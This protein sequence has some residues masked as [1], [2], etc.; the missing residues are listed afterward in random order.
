MTSHQHR[1]HLALCF[2]IIGCLLLFQN[3]SC[4]KRQ[5]LVSKKATISDIH[6]AQSIVFP[7]EG[8]RQVLLLESYDKW[9]LELQDKDNK[10]LD[11]ETQTGDAGT[12]NIVV[13]T[14]ENKGKE[15][16]TKVDMLLAN[17]T[18]VAT[19]R[20]IQQ[21]AKGKG[22]LGQEHIQGNID[23]IELPRFSGSA[24]DYF[25]TH[26]VDGGRRV[27]YSIEYHTPLRHARWVCFSFDNVTAAINTERN[28]AW[29]WD[30]L[31]P[32]SYEVTREHFKGFDR[33]HLV[34]S[35]DRVFSA[36]ANKQTFFYTNMSP[37][38]AKF[39][40]VAWQQLERTVQDWAHTEGFADNIY[41]AKGGTIRP[42][43]Y[44]D[45]LSGGKIA[46]PKHYWM[47]ILV[48]KDGEWRSMAFWIG[49]D[50][51]KRQQG[52]LASL[53]CSIDE[54]EKRTGLDFFFNLPDDI[55]NVVEAQ[56]PANSTEHWPGL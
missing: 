13:N 31:V 52:G 17:G 49:H 32:P 19:L 46:V 22:L 47:A 35:F 56:I 10:W 50:K 20:F 9:T 51:D 42:G 43:E 44:E 38:R 16:E 14:S 48:Q 40:Q 26:H 41:I 30:P 27:N 24:D 21:G 53:T 15:R 55:E 23:L 28:D 54:L 39:N 34:A 7:K 25:I 29:G 36:E 2:F 18:K 6:G 12:S 11:I 45:E 33:G 8:G 4:E 5:K 1:N 37:Q 3:G